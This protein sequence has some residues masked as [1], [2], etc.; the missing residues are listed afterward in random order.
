ML[1]DLTFYT[2]QS[3]GYDANAS[4]KASVLASQPSPRHFPS[5]KHVV[6]LPETFVFP[7][8]SLKTSLLLRTQGL[9][10]FGTFNIYTVS[11]QGLLHAAPRK[12][13][14]PMITVQSEKLSLKCNVRKQ[15]LEI[16]PFYHP[17]KKM[18][19]IGKK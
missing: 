2:C 1:T 3:Q 13:P 17:K 5:W 8:L 15:I 4:R 12:T 18:I 14:S 7:R 6:F 16:H 19:L 11:E 10:S 9:K